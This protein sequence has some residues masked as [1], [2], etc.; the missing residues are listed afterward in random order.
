MTDANPPRRRRG[1][2]TFHGDDAVALVESGTMSY[3]E[4]ASPEDAHAMLGDGST[5]AA[6]AAGA[7]STV[8]FRGDGEDGG[9][10]LVRAWFAPHY[11]LP[12]HSHDGD[13]LYYIVEGTVTMGSQV[14]RAGDGFFV[15][16]DAPYAYEVGP[17][18]A[19]VLE[20]RSRTSFG[21]KVASRQDARFRRMNDI[22][23]AH[24]EQWT[25][26]RASAAR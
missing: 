2:V 16:S 26:L 19:V 22:A 3:P 12:R 14:L 17:D 23:V 18:G 11:V 20:F 1:L 13:C 15:P 25:E 7:E 21:M 4:F 5:M 8:L 6:V 10:S 24:F 9:A